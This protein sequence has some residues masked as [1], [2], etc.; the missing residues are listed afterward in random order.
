MICVA[1][2]HDVP[3]TTT[4]AATSVPSMTPSLPQAAAPA[5]AGFATSSSAANSSRT[6]GT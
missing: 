3:Y 1:A 6:S 2:H 5:G 4:G